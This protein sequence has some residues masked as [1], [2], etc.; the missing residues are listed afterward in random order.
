MKYKRKKVEYVPTAREL[1]W[2]D[3]E[4]KRR[5]AELDSMFCLSESEWSACEQRLQRRGLEVLQQRRAN[6]EQ[7]HRGFRERR[8]V[9]SEV[10]ESETET[11][12]GSFC[13]FCGSPGRRRG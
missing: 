10:D 6:N 9:S 11:W 2:L 1:D 5:L 3:R 4:V 12:D 7:W 13:F 8:V